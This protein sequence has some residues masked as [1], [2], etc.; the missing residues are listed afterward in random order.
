[1][2]VDLGT[3]YLGLNLRNPVVA[4][5][6][7]LTGKLDTLR[8]LDDHGIA[9]V[10]LP[11]LF[12]EQ[13]EHDELQ[14]DRLLGFQAESFAESLS[15]FPDTADFGKGSQEYLELIAETKRA[16]SVPVIASL[17]GQSPGGWTRY[18]RWIEDAGA[19]ALELNVYFVPTDCAMDGQEVERRYVELVSDVR[20]SVKMPLAVKIGSQFSSIP[21]MAFRLMEAGADGLVLFNRFL[22]PDIDLETLE[23]FPD[24]VLSQRYEIR[25]PLRWIAILRDQLQ[26]SLAATSGIHDT[27]NVLR[28]LLAGADVAMMTT[29]LLKRGPAV[30]RRIVDELADWLTEN[31]YASIEQL[32]GSMSRANCP[33]PSAL[34]RANYMKAL[35]TYTPDYWSS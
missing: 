3:T 14:L 35:A 13:I 1:M 31:D 25:L 9:A 21:N 17:N 33:D 30:V 6:G 15:Y 2:S 11:S 22:E 4:S 23:F 19:D 28:A 5:A 27:S 8:Q 7:P 20:Q 12:E 10:V 24:L 18:A 26:C 32:K 29:G 16:M 34:E